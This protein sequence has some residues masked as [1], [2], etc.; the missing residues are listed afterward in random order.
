M[1]SWDGNNRKAECFVR[2]DAEKEKRHNEFMEKMAFQCANT[3]GKSFNM[4]NPF[5]D[6]ESD[7]LRMNF[8]HDSIA[9]NGIAAVLFAIGKMLPS[10]IKTAVLMA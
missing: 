9:R 10:Y 4:A 6:A 1:V 3:M 2:F 7:E 8:I 5:L